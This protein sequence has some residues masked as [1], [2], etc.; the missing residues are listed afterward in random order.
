VTERQVAIENMAQGITIAGSHY[1]D[2]GVVFTYDF[3]P[4]MLIMDEHHEGMIEFCV[5]LC[6]INIFLSIFYVFI[7]LSIIYPFSYLSIIYLRIYL[8]IYLYS[9]YVCI[10]LHIYL[11]IYNLYLCI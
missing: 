7:Y 3:Y 6:G 2:L 10:Y 1:A 5:T 11:S 8:F 9:I 4:L